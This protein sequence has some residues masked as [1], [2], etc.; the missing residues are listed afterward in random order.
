MSRVDFESDVGVE[1][2]LLCSSSDATH[3]SL[4]VLLEMLVLITIPWKDRLRGP[5]CFSASFS[6]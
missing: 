6:L 1:V 5:S 2:Q 3:M 4:A